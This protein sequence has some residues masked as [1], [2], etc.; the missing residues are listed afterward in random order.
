MDKRRT[1]SKD[2][3]LFL[4][5]QPKPPAMNKRFLCSLAFFLL[6]FVNASAQ[7]PNHIVISQVY[8]GGGNAGAQ[9]RNDFVE[10]YNPTSSAVNLSGWSLQYAASTGNFALATKLDLVGVMQPG[11]Y[12]LIHLGASGANGVSLPTAD[13]TSSFG[14]ATGSGKIALVQ[15]TSVLSS[16]CN[17]AVIGSVDFVGYGSANCFEGSS[18]TTVLNN[19]T[20]AFRKSNGCIDTDQ[21]GGDFLELAPSPRNSQSPAHN[22]GTNITISS[23]NP[24]PFCVYANSGAQ[25]T[26]AY[27]ITGTLPANLSVYLSDA[28]GSFGNNLVVGTALAQAIGTIALTIPA[29]L[30]SSTQYRLRVDG[31]NA[32]GEASNSFEIINGAKNVT[33]LNVFP[34]QQDASVQWPAPT[35]CYDEFLVVGK[36][37][38]AITGSPSGDG[39]AYVADA[40]FAGVGTAFGGGKVVYKGSG[41]N[42]LVSGLTLGQTYYFKIFTRRG[43]DWSSGV[44]T[45]VTTRVIPGAG[46]VLINGF[47]PRYHNAPGEYIELVNVT[48]KT[49]NLA[50]IQI[51]TQDNTGVAALLPTILSGTLQPHSFWILSRADS[52]TVNVGKTVALA[53]DG[54]SG[55]NRSDNGYIGLVRRKDN[56]VLDALG[57]GTVANGTLVEGQ[58]AG[59]IPGG[60]GGGIRRKIDGMDN[61]NNSTDFEV[62]SL[63]AID[64][65]NSASRLANTNAAINAGNYARMYVTGNSSIAGNVTLSEKL[66]LI[67]GKIALGGN[68]LTTAATEGGS[69][70]SYAQSNGAGVLAASAIAAT[71]FRFPIG[72]TTYNP[73]SIANGSGLA[74]SVRVGDGVTATGADLAVQRTWHI[75]PSAQPSSGADIIFQY[76]EGDAAQL[77]ANFSSAGGVQVWHYHSSSWQKAGPV[78]QPTGTAG[79]LRTVSLN[80]WTLFSPF[81]LAGASAILPVRF[82]A[83]HLLEAGHQKV[84]EFTAHNEWEIKHYEIEWSP[85]GNRFVSIGIVLP[86]N[87]RGGTEV[88]RFVD[89]RP[90]AGRSYFRIKAVEQDGNLLYSAVLSATLRTALPK[91]VVFP[92]P[93]RQA[94]I[95]YHLGNLPAGNYQLKIVDASGRQVWLQS[96][97]HEGGLVSGLV[98]GQKLASGVY[99]FIVQGSLRMQQAF[100]VQ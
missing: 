61:N 63:D 11:T 37:G 90:I 16:T 62:V 40:N 56:L 8:G 87:N 33:S 48:G 60:T 43:T 18:G 98:S 46:E 21:N 70:N 47:S 77:G 5:P 78:V 86:K 96:L 74:W 59:T 35:G 3:A 50:D 15:T 80:G 2:A 82:G 75:Q 41:T 24:L 17:D 83:L 12:F 44:E 73:L 28:T 65:R 22:C 89:S 13:Q 25:A 91:L 34:D 71:P 27:S 55:N 100:V 6:C 42:V 72:N 93:I 14:I 30:A 19:T 10:L 97:H 67:Q 51:N 1:P 94:S 64:L 92:S 66:V 84:L 45:S 7:S 9:Y 81:V 69:A 57:Y 49:F 39:S 52:A 54:N 53:K 76:D 79:G 99:Y 36:T 95:H 31:N 4:S 26:V 68:N 38:G 32:Y 20:A 23:I 85:E 29:G 58:P 88:Y